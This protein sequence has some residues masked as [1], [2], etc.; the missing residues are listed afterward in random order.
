MSRPPADVARTA[1]LARTVVARL[2]PEELPA[3][4]ILAAPYLTGA[5]ASIDGGRLEFGVLEAIATVTPVVTLVSASVTAALL[6]GAEGE[7][8]QLGGQATRGLFGALRRRREPAPPAPVE[9]SREQLVRVRE[10]ATARAAAL[11]VAPP[12]AATIADAVVG[13][14]L[15]DGE[16]ER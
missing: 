3:F 1:A 7:L 5:D 14:L 11:G 10:V 15:L 12:L 16:P 6:R 2:A 9:F 13:A 8:E 4:D